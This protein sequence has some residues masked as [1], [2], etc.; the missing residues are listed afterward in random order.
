MEQYIRPD[1]ADLDKENKLDELL[2]QLPDYFDGYTQRAIDSSG[3][4][5]E[6]EM[7]LFCKKKTAVLLPEQEKQK[8]AALIQEDNC[9]DREEQYVFI[10]KIASN[11][12]NAFDISKIT[13]PIT[14]SAMTKCKYVKSLQKIPVKTQNGYCDREF[15][16]ANSENTKD[17]NVLFRRLCRDFIRLKLKNRDNNVIS[18]YP[19]N[20]VGIFEEKG[21]YFHHIGKL[22]ELFLR[23]SNHFE[24][25]TY[26][27]CDEPCTQET[28]ERSYKTNYSSYQFV[29][30][31]G[32]Q[33][34]DRQKAA[35]L[36]KY[37][38][39]FKYVQKKD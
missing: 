16:V 17:C 1:Y 27:V 39:S 32:T 13:D 14:K 6:Y 31:V 22:V 19:Y 12:S 5:S 36:A 3:T 26:T 15:I 28:Y 20:E 21:G 4:Y 8:L 23:Y 18:D 29:I 24:K 2:L 33:P 38:W 10:G 9:D 25:G 7:P 37:V 35:E 30:L 34:Q 11:A